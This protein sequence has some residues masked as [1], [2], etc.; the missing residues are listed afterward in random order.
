MEHLSREFTSHINRSTNWKTSLCFAG[1]FSNLQQWDLSITRILKKANWRS[2]S[3]GRVSGS[4]R[5]LPWRRSSLRE[6][7]R[8]RRRCWWDPSRPPL[9]QERDKLPRRGGRP[10]TGSHG[11]CEHL[12]KS[13]FPFAFR[14]FVVAL[15]QGSQKHE[16]TALE[17]FWR[18]CQI[19][20]HNDSRPPQGQW[21]G[22]RP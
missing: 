3:T 5:W 2:F 20:F 11:L 10:D 13:S 4:L 15:S 6:G 9:A 17:A 18:N 12:A 14:P 19:F 8:S 22:R 16:R 1:L 7:R 21:T